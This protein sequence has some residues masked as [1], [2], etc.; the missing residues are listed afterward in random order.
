MKQAS[1]DRMRTSVTRL[2]MRTG[3]GHRVESGA[4]NPH[5]AK[6]RALLFSALLAQYS[7]VLSWA[8]GTAAAQTQWS[9]GMTVWP[10]EWD[11]WVTSPK[12]TGVAL[13]TSRFQTVQAIGSPTRVSAIRWAA[14][15]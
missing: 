6:C 9:V 3:W 2:A 10:N 13:G 11:S 4:V 7:P 1:V 5:F 12:G 8:R 14:D 15:T